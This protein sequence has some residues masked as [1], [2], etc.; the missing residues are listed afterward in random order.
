[1]VAADV[2]VI[3]GFKIYGKHGR[4]LGGFSKRV[5]I[6]LWTSVAVA[7]LGDDESFWSFDPTLGPNEWCDGFPILFD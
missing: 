3:G 2:A 7:P 6:C 4:M 1:M 5:K